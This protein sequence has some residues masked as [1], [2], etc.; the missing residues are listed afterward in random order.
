MPARTVLVAVVAAAA[1]LNGAAARPT[2]LEPSS[3]LVPQPRTLTTTLGKWLAENGSEEQGSTAGGGR[4]GCSDKALRFID[5]LNEYRAEKGEPPIPASDSMCFVSDT[6]VRDLEHHSP[7]GTGSDHCGM[8]SWSDEGPWSSCCYPDTRFNSDPSE[9]V[10]RC[11]WDKPR[12][13]TGYPD[14][15]YENTLFYPDAD[16]EITPWAALEAWKKSNSHH[17]IMIN[18]GSWKDNTFKAVGA[19]F[20][21]MYAVMWVGEAT[22][23]VGGGGVTGDS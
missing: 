22:D 8:H 21:G 10:Q 20:Y 11:S 16:N 5:L 17:Q 19:G 1:T 12:E 23:H 3:G 15:G 4:T 13:L 6:H 18:G 2:L 14:N 7:D 9:A